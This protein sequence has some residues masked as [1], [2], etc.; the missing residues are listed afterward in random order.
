MFFKRVNFFVRKRCPLFFYELQR[1]LKNDLVPLYIFSFHGITII[2]IACKVKR[3]FPK[4]MLF[5]AF[6]MLFHEGKTRNR[7]ETSHFVLV[8]PRNFSFLPKFYTCFYSTIRQQLDED[9][10][11]VDYSLIDNSA[12]LSNCFSIHFMPRIVYNYQGNSSETFFV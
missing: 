10:V 11:Q 2:S 8:F 9:E 6:K 1:S 7:V 12:S 4:K 5:F 3:H